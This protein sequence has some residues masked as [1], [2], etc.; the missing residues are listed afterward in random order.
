MTSDFSQHLTDG[1]NKNSTLRASQVELKQ[2]KDNC[3]L[4]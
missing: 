3:R 1:V 4:F 2:L